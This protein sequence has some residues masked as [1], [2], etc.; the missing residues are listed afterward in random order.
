MAQFFNSREVQPKQ[1]TEIKVLMLFIFDKN[2]C[3][4]IIL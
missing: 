2:L 1:S 4:T 3:L